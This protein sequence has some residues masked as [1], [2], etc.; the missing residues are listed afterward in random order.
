MVVNDETA[1][2]KTEYLP[3]DPRRLRLFAPLF[4]KEEG[5]RVNFSRPN[6]M[7]LESKR[8]YVF[9]DH[10]MLTQD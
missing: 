3:C 5:R 8:H 9:G 4:L 6:S 1:T 7:L 2:C 10:E